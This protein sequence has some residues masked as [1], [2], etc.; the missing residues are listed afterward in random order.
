[1]DFIWD[2]TMMTSKFIIAIYLIVTIFKY[3]LK[4]NLIIW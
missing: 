2:G 3:T 4:N 1:M